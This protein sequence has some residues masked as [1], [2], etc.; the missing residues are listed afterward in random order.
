[1]LENKFDSPKLHFGVFVSTSIF[2]Q[3]KA[4]LK[5]DVGL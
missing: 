1:M 5:E 3:I 2:E 4:G